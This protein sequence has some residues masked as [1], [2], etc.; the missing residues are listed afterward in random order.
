MRDP[1]PG[2]AWSL[3]RVCRRIAYRDY[4][5][6]PAWFARREGW[7]T[8]W[9]ARHGAE[10]CCLVCGSVWSLRHDDLHHRS[11]AR[12]GHEARHDLIPLCR[13]CHR[14][15]H[16]V[17]ECDPSWRRL[18]RTQATDLIVVAL[19]HKALDHRSAGSEARSHER[20]CHEQGDPQ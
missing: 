19:R 15:L 4:M 7:A 2:I 20:R 10:P 12:L 18:D 5:A 14:A 16:R 11:Y 17:L 9:T 6:S 1:R 3:R 8:D 13:R